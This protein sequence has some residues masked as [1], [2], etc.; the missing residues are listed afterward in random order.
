MAMR[1]EGEFNPFTEIKRGVRQRCVVSPELLN[2]YSEMILREINQIEAGMGLVTKKWGGHVSG[3]SKKWGSVGLPA[4][5]VFR[6]TPS[7]RS[8]NAPFSRSGRRCVHR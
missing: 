5:K 8:E 6:A 2:I 4:G 3:E 1:V 7:R